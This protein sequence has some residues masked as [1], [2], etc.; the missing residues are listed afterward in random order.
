[1]QTVQDIKKL[2]GRRKISV[3]TA[4]DYWTSIILDEIGVD[5]VLVG[6]SLGMVMLGYKNTLPVSMDEMI[7]H[8]KAVARGTKNAIIVGDMPF[9][10]DISARDAV[11]N[12]GRFIKEGGAGAVK[13]EG[14]EKFKEIVKAVVDNGIPV[15]GHIGL[16][17]QDVLVLGGYKRQDDRQRLLD[18]AL[19]IQ[20]AGAFS[21]VIECVP[22][23]IAAEIT[24]KVNV[25]TISCGSGNRCDGQVAVMHDV[26]GLCPQLT[27][28]FIKPHAE[29]KNNIV[30]ALT[31]W[32]NDI[33]K[34]S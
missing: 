11:I 18:D 32:K 10:S 1:M 31:K 3:L 14:G 13:I 5:L 26:L 9:I 4:Y 8:T 19:S 28:K 7:H 27:P 6:D 23:E 30:N 15:M 21:L 20:E 33:S 22:E 17:P 24:E 29:I 25:P 16:T 12:A 34:K 2:K